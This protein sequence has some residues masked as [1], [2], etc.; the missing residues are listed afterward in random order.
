MMNL[1]FE[2]IKA[3]GNSHPGSPQRREMIDLSLPQTSVSMRKALGI[4]IFFSF[5][6]YSSTGPSKMPPWLG[7]EN[8]KDKLARKEGWKA[9][10]A[11][12]TA[13]PHTP[14]TAPQTL[15]LLSEVES[16]P[17]GALCVTFS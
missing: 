5:W 10:E 8:L 16:L 13:L 7:I 6:D 4:C 12:V 11:G 14:P 2:I 1:K 9:V 15:A 3:F 17:G